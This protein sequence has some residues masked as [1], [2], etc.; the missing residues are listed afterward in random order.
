[1]LIAIIYPTYIT[2]NELIAHEPQW[3]SLVAEESL[4][5]VNEKQKETEEKS[6]SDNEDEDKIDTENEDKVDSE[7][8]EEDVDTEITEK[9]VSM[10]L[11]DLAPLSSIS[12]VTLNKLELGDVDE[13]INLLMQMSMLKA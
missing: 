8:E 4:K 6:N 2:D 7:D 10:S 5:I 1:M 13:L 9:P 11:K 12:E 3:D